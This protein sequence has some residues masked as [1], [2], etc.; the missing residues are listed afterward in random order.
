MSVSATVTR[1]RNY[2]DGASYGDWETS[3]YPIAGY[4]YSGSNWVAII[5]FTTEKLTREL[6]L[7]L[8][9]GNIR[10]AYTKVNYKILDTEADSEYIN[11]DY[12]TASDGAIEMNK[13]D[14]TASNFALSLNK[15]LK[16]GIHYLYL[17]TAMSTD[18]QCYFEF[19]FNKNDGTVTIVYEE[20]DGAVNVGD[21]K[22]V[23]KVWD[24][25]QW[26]IGMVKVWDGT[27]WR[28]GG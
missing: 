24:G 12:T 7:G 18:Y 6:T 10:G 16:A 22:G 26:R 4:G 19:C 27:Q 28:I 13:Y 25:T 1:T 8:V 14:F 21:R 20:I 11:A 9:N 23:V 2:K 17:W 3:D 15:P 5:E